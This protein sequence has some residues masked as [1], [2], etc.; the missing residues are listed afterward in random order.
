[1]IWTREKSGLIWFNESVARCS[2]I[3]GAKA[4]SDQAVLPNRS[5]EAKTLHALGSYTCL[6]FS[7]CKLVSQNKTS[8][9]VKVAFERLQ[10]KLTKPLRK[11]TL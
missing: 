7:V 8:I 6:Y 11:S 4:P 9:R 3:T 10:S 5:A 1:M 2:Y